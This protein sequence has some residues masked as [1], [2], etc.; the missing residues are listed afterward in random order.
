M[1]YEWIISASKGEIVFSVILSLAYTV[2]LYGTGPLLF[3]RFN[4]KAI[5]P[6]R[7]ILFSTAYT[8]L[9][10]LLSNMLQVFIFNGEV[11][12]GGAAFLWGWIFYLSSKRHLFKKGFL[13]TRSVAVSTENAGAPEERWYTCQKC[14]QLV[15]D[16]CTC[17]CEAAKRHLE[18]GCEP[19]PVTQNHEQEKTETP[20]KKKRTT[21]EVG[22]IA[23]CGILILTTTVL[24]YHV[25]KFRAAS[26]AAIEASDS[27]LLENKRLQ[28]QVEASQSSEAALQNRVQELE[29]R[30]NRL[31]DYLRDA[32]F[33]YNNIGF[34][35]SGSSV[36]HNYE[37][38]VFQEAD[39]Y[40]AH[41]IEY[42]EYMGYAPCRKCW[43]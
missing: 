3:C 5:T 33:L 37:C 11:S 20:Q 25:H 8:F 27:L 10:W 1:D 4:K 29:E 40:W 14:G 22:L 38:P 39:E 36:Y 17:D 28:D 30:N 34:I 32:I 43:K 12:N 26:I 13:G 18:V 42:C 41:N 21:L 7:L 15:R 24:G 2:A 35:V 19:V 16:G 9:A 31:A 6:K 23:A